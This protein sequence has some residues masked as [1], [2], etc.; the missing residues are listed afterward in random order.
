MPDSWETANG[1]NPNL[2]DSAQDQNGDGYTN[3]EHFLDEMSDPPPQTITVNQTG[4]GSGTI[5]STPAGINCGSDCSEEYEY[6]TDVTLTTAPVGD[7]I[8]ISWSG[9]CA[10]PG[11]CLVSM[12][13]A[14]VVTAT[15]VTSTTP[16]VWQISEQGAYWYGVNNDIP[17]PADYNGDGRDDLALFR[18]SNSTWYIRG[19]GPALYGTTG[20]IPVVGDYNGDGRDD[21][22]VFRESNSTWY[23]RGIGPAL[24]GTVG[25]IPVVGDYNGDGRDDVAVFRP[26]NS[27]WYIRGIGPVQFGTGGDIPVVGDYNGDGRDDIAVFRPSNST[28]YIRGIGSFVYGSPGQLPVPAD[29][30]GDGK[31]D[32]AVFRP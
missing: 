16:G 28:W 23:I 15:F 13:A 25:D 7:S 31:T 9:A 19:I 18:E 3:L 11:S 12:N 1:L 24:Y 20:D 17:V 14:Q 6:N 30:N 27:T 5:M 26:S 4:P 21:V 29:Y 10:G 22:A 2:N 8:F 32:I